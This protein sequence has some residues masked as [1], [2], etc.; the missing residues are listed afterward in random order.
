VCIDKLLAERGKSNSLSGV[1]DEKF[2]INFKNL[3][4]QKKIIVLI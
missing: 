4:P 1:K 2:R 3:E